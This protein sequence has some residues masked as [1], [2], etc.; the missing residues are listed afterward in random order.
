MNESELSA[1][2]TDLFQEVRTISKTVAEIRV[3]NAWQTKALSE[4]QKRNE[5]MDVRCSG[6]RRAF[7]DEIKR[8]DVKLGEHDTVLA[9]HRTLGSIAWGISLLLATALGGVMAFFKWIER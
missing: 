6:Q 5:D 8:V 4:I 2:I 1:A 3:D 7:V 9:T